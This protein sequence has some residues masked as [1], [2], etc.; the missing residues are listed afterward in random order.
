N[1]VSTPH[2]GAPRPTRPIPP[3]RR[4][5]SHRGTIG[6]AT[7]KQPPEEQAMRHNGIL[8][9]ADCTE[10]R[11]TVQARPPRIV[12]GTALLLVTLLGSALVWSALTGADLVVRSPG[13]VRPVTAPKKIFN[14]GR[15]DVFSA[16]AG[17]R[18][19]EV[20]FREGDEV[21][22][23]DVLVRLDAE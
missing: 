16:S 17:G 19:L 18:V 13:R 10:F 14:A 2:F 22:Q 3:P 11:Q 4:P 7:A 5:W 21:R 1:R 15:G 8:D 23:G 6:T 12:H 9:L 20:N